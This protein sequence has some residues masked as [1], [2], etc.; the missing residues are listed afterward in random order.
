MSTRGQERE[1][2]WD[3]SVLAM[4]LTQPERFLPKEPGGVASDGST[5]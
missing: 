5:K 1:G 3:E 2:S 4:E